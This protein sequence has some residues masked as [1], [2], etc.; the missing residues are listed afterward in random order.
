MRY[1]SPPDSAILVAW[2]GSIATH[3]ANGEW[4]RLATALFV[5][6]SIPG[7]V[8]ALIALVTVGV[9][10]ERLVGSLAFAAVYLASGLLANLF[11]LAA[12]PMTVSV[13]S[14]GAI[15]GLYGLMVATSVWAVARVPRLKVPLAVLKALAG[16]ALVL[17]ASTAASGTLAA[18]IVGFV[19]GLSLGVALASGAHRRKVSPLGV[20]ASAA[21]TIALAMATAAPLR[22]FT[23]ATPAIQAIVAAEVRSSE[24]YRAA[25]AQFTTGAITADAL[26]RTIDEVIVPD[27]QA[28]R[29]RLASIE[30]PPRD[31]QILVTAA[32]EYLQLRD[33]SW[34]IRSEAL[35][36]HSARMLREADEKEAASLNALRRIV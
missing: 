26:A 24:M 14:S 27:L 22:G 13:G 7:L 15:A 18:A 9:V 17:L 20:A 25:V 6:G 35:R 32:E 19:T 12:F 1:G 8:S 34:R 33:Q 36:R 29:E 16:G 3:T 4:W 10:L 31:Q 23:D 2:G 30:Q 5:H 28:S 11:S 21:F